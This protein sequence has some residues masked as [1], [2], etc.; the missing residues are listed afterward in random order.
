MRRLKRDPGSRMYFDQRIRLPIDF[1]TFDE[2]KD[3]P[4]F[5]SAQRGNIE[6]INT[7]IERNY[8]L[9]IAHINGCVSNKT[10]DKLTQEDYFQYGVEGLR[11]AILKFNPKRGIKFSTY[12]SFW[13]RQAMFRAFY[14]NY[15]DFNFPIHLFKHKTRLREAKKKVNS[16]LEASKI[17]NIGERLLSQMM[18]ADPRSKSTYLNPKYEL[19]SEPALMI[20]KVADN[21]CVET[22]EHD[23][24]CDELMMALKKILNKKEY[25]VIVRR[26][27]LVD[28]DNCPR[29]EAQTLETIG[30]D[31]GLSRERI[32]QIEV[33]AITK[34]REDERFI[35]F[36]EYLKE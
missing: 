3:T 11:K 13:I 33:L 35:G 29:G 28:A 2:K 19:E 9:V 15:S 18:S 6:A 24:M 12:A 21:S 25:E 20:D 4:L 1:Q 16:I 10:G 32:R 22:I 31:M 36:R 26:F 27:G 7:L 17:A 30:K 8:G 14:Q 34:L 23:L 5:K